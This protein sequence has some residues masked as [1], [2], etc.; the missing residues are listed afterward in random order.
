MVRH[1]NL[2]GAVSTHSVT[3][4]ATQVTGFKIVNFFFQCQTADMLAQSIQGI[5]C[6]VGKNLMGFSEVIT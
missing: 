1:R 6:I 4:F 5:L 3:V 2:T